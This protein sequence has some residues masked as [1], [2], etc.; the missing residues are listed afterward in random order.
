VPNPSSTSRPTS[1]PAC[2]AGCD[3]WFDGCN[4][5]SCDQDNPGQCREGHATHN[6]CHQWNAPTCAKR[7]ETAL[8]SLNP[9]IPSPPTPRPSTVAA[10]PVGC[11]IWFDGC[12]YCTCDY[13]LPGKCL[14]GTTTR[15][16]CHEYQAPECGK[17]NQTPTPTVTPKIP[18]SQPTTL[19]ACPYG[20]R[21]WFDGCNYC[22][23]DGVGQ[24]DP[25]SI[26]HVHPDDCEANQAPKCMKSDDPDTTPMP[27]PNPTPARTYPTRRPTD[28]DQGREDTGGT[29]NGGA[30]T[31]SS[32]SNPAVIIILVLV[33]LLVLGFGGYWYYQTRV[34]ERSSDKYKTL[35]GGGK[36][37]FDENK[38][39]RV[40][41]ETFATHDL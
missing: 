24:C 1:T 22:H 4:Y 25:D 30:S 17:W 35:I 2:P 5:C 15:T 19:P 23:C 18:T 10:C 33:I 20:C 32:G 21:T 38:S 31:E 39:N 28:A 36:S 40:L 9:T 12:N 41:D 37:L 16:V 27:T 6:K 34:V 11:D 29:T 7:V 8:P 26:T 14:A 3:T 13:G